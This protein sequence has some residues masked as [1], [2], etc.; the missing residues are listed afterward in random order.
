MS[1]GNLYDYSPPRNKP[2][3]EGPNGQQYPAKTLDP[4]RQNIKDHKLG[5]SRRYRKK[6][7]G[8]QD[9]GLAPKISVNPVESNHK[10]MYREPTGEVATDVLSL[11]D[12]A[13]ANVE[14]FSKSA[15]MVE[16]DDD[17]N[18]EYKLKLIDHSSERLQQ[19]TTQMKFRIEEGNGEA[20]YKLGYEDNGHP[21]GLLKADLSQSL[22]SLCHLAKQLKAELVVLA[23]AKGAIGLVADVSVRRI[24]E[25]VKIE[26]KVMLLGASGSGKST[27]LGVLLTGTP[28]DGRGMARLRIL[29]HKHEMLTGTTS[30]LTYRVP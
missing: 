15:P 5:N 2:K 30:S 18:I 1:D 12:R 29:N 24:R 28:D 22:N 11:A 25:N 16:E 10:L 21:L 4:E 19:L 8:I 26:L 3:K 27:L 14:A 20:F 6:K 17:G 13:F 7:P 23:L 9:K